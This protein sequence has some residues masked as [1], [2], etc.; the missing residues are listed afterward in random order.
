MTE[1]IDNKDLTEDAESIN[2]DEE[3]KKICNDFRDSIF[4]LLQRRKG[5]EHFILYC[6]NPQTAVHMP[7]K[8]EIVSTL[9]HT[10][11]SVT[12]SRKIHKYN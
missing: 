6:Q 2:F 5:I 3:Y 9:F 11:A 4:H 1:N 10:F 12:R 7:Y 8:K